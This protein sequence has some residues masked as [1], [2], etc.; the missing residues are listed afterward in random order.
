VRGSAARG[1][2][3]KGSAAGEVKGSAAGEVRGS[4]AGEVRVLLL[5][6]CQGGGKVVEVVG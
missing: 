6:N 4:A 5:L 1:G 2:E 3:V